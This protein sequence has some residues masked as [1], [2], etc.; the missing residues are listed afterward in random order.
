MPELFPRDEDLIDQVAAAQPLAVQTLYQRHGRL[1]YGIA[2]GIL[3]DSSAAEEVT[4][5]VFLRV[6]EKAASYKAEKARVITW[7]MRIARNQSIDALRRRS[8]RGGAQQDSLDDFSRLADPG[9]PDPG[10]SAALAFRREEVRAALRVLPAD[11]RTAL[12]LAF[13]P[14]AHP[15]ADRGE[16]GGA[17]GHRED[18]HPRFHAE[19]APGPGEGG[20]AVTIPGL[21]IFVYTCDAHGGTCASK[22]CC[23]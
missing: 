13:F 6:W 7:I 5:D 21:G 12:S 1:V 9:S 18:A 19:A 10:E 11:Q 4:Q 23:R 22:E 2:L 8:S 16:A 17:A 15:P 3:R 20:G 14:G